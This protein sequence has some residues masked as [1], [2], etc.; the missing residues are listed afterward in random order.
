MH[1]ANSNG[2][3]VADVAASG[4]SLHDNAISVEM[5]QA[6]SD[7]LGD[8]AIAELQ[9][10]GQTYAARNLL[11]ARSV[12]ELA[13]SPELRALVEPILGDSSFP[14]R[15]LLFD[16]VPGANWNLGWHQDVVIPVAV[17]K[18]VAGFSAWSVK[19]GVPHVRPPVGVL[20]NMLAVRI[21]LDDCDRDNGALR[22]IP[23]SHVHGI[24]GDDQIKSI[25]DREIP[26]LC[27]AARGSALL[28]RPLLLHSSAPAKSP[29]HRRIVH[30]EFAAGPLPGGLEW[31]T[32]YV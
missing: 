2:T 17:R 27:E 12:R 1:V 20:E 32:W 31:P 28:M 26:V 22:V 9:R 21:H 29:R 25:V 18:D 3:L 11:A 16:K 4:F 30:I 7:E 19:R 8:L 5:L 14:V 6:V 10:G 23:G 24:L 15:G 13:S